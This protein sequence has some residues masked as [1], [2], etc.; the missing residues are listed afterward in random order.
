MVRPISESGFSMN[1]IQI[2]GI[3]VPLAGCGSD[4]PSGA[5]NALRLIVES[6][7]AVIVLSSEWRRHATLRDG[8]ETKLKSEGMSLHDATRTDLD[9]RTFMTDADGSEGG[10]RNAFAERRVREIGAYLKA[11]PG[12]TSWVALDDVDL[13][14]ADRSKAK[15]KPVMRENFVHTVDK[16]GLTYQDARRAIHIL[17]RKPLATVAPPPS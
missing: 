6:T 9:L 13:S 16:I 3:S 4:F 5:V 17:E 7:G 10:M 12:I 1:T 14:A 15:D 8:V 11:H 2:D